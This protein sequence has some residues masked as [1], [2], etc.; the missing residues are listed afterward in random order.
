MQ[1]QGKTIVEEYK[2]KA[3][4]VYEDIVKEAHE[5]ADRIIK[6]KIR[7]GKAKEKCRR[8]NK[9]RSSRTCSIGF[10]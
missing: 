2:S 4:N 9:G 7:S 1:K 8:R 10:F 3:E 6:I 5:E